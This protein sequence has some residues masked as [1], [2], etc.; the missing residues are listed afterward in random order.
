MIAEGDKVVTRLTAYGRHERDLPGIPAT[1]HQLTMKA[2][3]IHRLA[4][5]A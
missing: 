1:R 3:A 4:A 2:V 5:W